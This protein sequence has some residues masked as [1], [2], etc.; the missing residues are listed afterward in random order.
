MSAASPTTASDEELQRFSESERYYLETSAFNHLFDTFT[1][2]EIELTRAYMRRKGVIFVTSPTVLWEIMLVSDR[3]RADE[4]L[5]AAQALF[6][7][8]LLGTPTELTVRYMRS[9][10][11][12]NVINYDVVTSLSW[13]SSWPAMTRELRRTFDY[14]IDQ[15][16]AKTAPIRQVSRNLKT[17]IESEGHERDMVGL[18]AKFVS[19][20]F[21]AIHE[22]IE[23]S[24]LDEVTAK[25]VIL[26]GF[27]L[28]MTGADL[29]EEPA[30]EFWREKGFY[31]E[32]AHAEVT[33]MFT[34]YPDIFRQGPLV[35]MA[36]MAALQY[37]S[38]KTNRGALHD[39]MH[40]IY[41]PHVHAILSNDAA[42][43]D[44]A[45]TF[46]WMRAKVRHIS[47]INLRMLEVPLYEYPDALHT[48]DGLEG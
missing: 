18:T 7:P 8:V 33:R 32:D 30:R 23:L 4:M 34:D 28:L 27:L 42:F 19:M 31:G 48:R 10:Y 9:A 26:Y 2:Q 37:K 17:V 14:D 35:T 46:P 36:V 47:E 43:L 6:D 3:E 40:L 22:D 15:L 38:G 5:L 41:A 24:K 13:A 29:D 45:G 11:P 20:V 1:L 25:M 21:G 39:G 16:R 44:L 12:Q